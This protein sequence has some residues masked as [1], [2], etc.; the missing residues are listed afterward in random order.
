MKPVLIPSMSW[1]EVSYSSPYT[2]QCSK[3]KEGWPLQSTETGLMS[4]GGSFVFLG[5]IFSMARSLQLS[6]YRP[7]L[8]FMT[9][10][11]YIPVLFEKILACTFHVSATLGFLNSLPV[12][13]MLN[14]GKF[15]QFSILNFHDKLVKMA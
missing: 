7:R 2:P 11:A 10:S 14:L 3:L 4:C 6:S 1:V 9:F 15:S 8:P 13:K 12:R 5:D